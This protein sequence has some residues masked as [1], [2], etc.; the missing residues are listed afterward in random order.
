MCSSRD[1][2]RKFRFRSGDFAPSHSIFSGPFNQQTSA[3]AFASGGGGIFKI[4]MKP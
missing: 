1:A 4:E 3:A 2:S